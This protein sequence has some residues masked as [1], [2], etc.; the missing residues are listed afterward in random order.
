MISYLTNTKK[1]S[2]IFKYFHPSRV[3]MLGSMESGKT[4]NG[5]P[6]KFLKNKSKLNK[7]YAETSSEAPGI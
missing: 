3:R 1:V 2:T 4:I 7:D 6:R 5:F